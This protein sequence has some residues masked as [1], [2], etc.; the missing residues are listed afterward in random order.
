MC[1]NLQRMAQHGFAEQYGFVPRTYQL[2][3][4]LPDLMAALRKGRGD[5][6]PCTYIIKPSSGAQVGVLLCSLACQECFSVVFMVI[7]K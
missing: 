3:A 1:R 2:P 5:G 4:H 7:C 6:A